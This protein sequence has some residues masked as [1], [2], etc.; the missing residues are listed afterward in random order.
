MLLPNIESV[1]KLMGITVEEALL[2]K[3]PDQVGPGEISL[4]TLAN[5][6]AGHSSPRRATVQK[7]LEW[8]ASKLGTNAANI[9]IHM[10]TLLE[11]RD[12]YSGPWHCL[13]KGAELA[14]SPVP[15]EIREAKRLVDASYAL[16]PAVIA[17]DPRS[18]AEMIDSLDL[19]TTEITRAVVARLRTQNDNSLESLA[20]T[21]GPLMLSNLMYLL[22]CWDAE[23]VAKLIPVFD[24]GK[25]K[26]PM[27]RW[28]DAIRADKG[29]TN[30]EQLG[31][32]F[33]PL[34]APPSKKRE[35]KKWRQGKLPTWKAV[36][37]IATRKDNVD[38]DTLRIAFAVIH[39]LHGIDNVAKALEAKGT[40]FSRRAFFASFPQL[41][42]FAKTKEAASSPARVVPG[43]GVDA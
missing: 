34:W 16:K 23:T 25:D 11:P 3:R 36:R 40:G 10:E 22:A 13:Y 32:Y 37:K 19:P 43:A 31:Q 30:D 29:L 14:G 18:L 35:M 15:L 21:C 12:A 8:V 1:F 27:E 38:S 17:Q 20:L 7:F 33:F 24:K 6:N 39:L 9:P 4:R 2:L 5:W 42:E 28:L 41:C 26:L